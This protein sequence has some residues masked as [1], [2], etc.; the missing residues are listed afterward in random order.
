[1]DVDG[2]L[3]DEH[4]MAPDAVEQLRPRE[5]PS[6]ALHE[7]FEKPEF[8]RPEMQLASA[9]THTVGLPV[10]FDITRPEHGCNQIRLGATQD[11][12]DPSQ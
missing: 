12:S 2:T 9:T 10:E 5:H 6:R 3:V 7:K 8:G 11:R 4:I 1:M